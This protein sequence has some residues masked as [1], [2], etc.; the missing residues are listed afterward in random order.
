MIITVVTSNPGKLREFRG[1]LEPLAVEVVH[2]TADCE[3]IQADTLEEVVLSCLHQL[4]SQ[5][6]KDFVI[7]DSGL[8]VHS[9]K[10][11]PGVYSSYAFKTLGNPGLIRLLEGE[12]D[13][14]AHFECCIGCHIESGSF[15]VKGRCDGEISGEE[16]GRGG[17]GFDPVFIPKGY[18][19]TFA[20]LPLQ[21]KNKI[22]HRG[23]AIQAFAEELQRR[24]GGKA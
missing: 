11:F 24:T 19:A 7:D 23:R 13:R 4:R 2:S 16:R 12:R 17:F 14:S 8:F 9:L 6:L 5:G 1:A 3:E 20:E 15:V 18:N 21:E 22:S 10:G